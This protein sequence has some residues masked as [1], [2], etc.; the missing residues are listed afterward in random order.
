LIIIFLLL[1][2]LLRVWDATR[3]PPGFSTAELAV[4]Y[5]VDQDR[6][7]A[8][9]FGIGSAFV[10]ELVGDG[11]LGFRVFPIWTSLITLALLFV[12][13]RR[14]FGVPVA[15]IALGIMALNLRAIILAR[16]VTAESLIPIYVLL[17]LICL[18]GTFNVRDEVRF[19][20][21]T[22]LSFALLAVLLGGSGYLHYSGLILGPIGILFFIHL[23]ITR[24]PLSRRVWSAWVFLLALA[25]IVAIPYLVSTLREPEISEPYILVAARPHSLTDAVNGVLSAVGGVIWQGD[26]RADNNLPEMPLF[27]PVTA[28][29]LIGGVISAVRRW[30]EPRYA[31]LLI[32]LVAGL[33]T[34]AWVEPESTFSANL[35]ALPALMMLPGLGAVELVRILRGR[36]VAQAWQPV[37]MIVTVGLIAS[38]FATRDHLFYDWKHH[39]Q[40][41]AAYHADLGYLAAYLDRT[42]DDLPVSFCTARLTEPLSAGLSPLQILPLMMHREDVPMRHSD[43]RGGIVLINAG[44]P[45]R[46]AFGSLLD[47]ANMPPELSEWLT[48]GEP[49]PVEG[50]VDGSVLRLDVEQ[51][52]RDAGGYW[53]T[54]SPTFFMPD[55]TGSTEQIAL[56]IALENN[57]TF[58]GYDP[59]AL[60]TARVAGGDPIVLVSYWRVDGPLPDDLGIFAHLLAYPDTES[61]VPL[62]EPWAEANALDVRPAELENR[63]FFA[64]VSYIWLSDSLAPGL[65]ALTVGAYT[66][67]VAVLENHLEVLDSAL[68]NQPHGER[69]LLGDVTVN[70]PPDPAEETTSN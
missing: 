63:D 35:V 68:N 65:Y 9:M 69:L 48:G 27:G 57:L 24:Q 18:I 41:R 12:L 19:R 53:A 51:Q 22:T 62:L 33:L 26:A 61:R 28:L 59:R 11:L 31:L 23:L 29:L 13:A 50:L 42:P 30:R 40:T 4:Y 37:V 1:A 46:F 2:A 20:N 21:P 5:R 8:G 34:D 14:L 70:P 32:V 45:M 25:T 47:R 10:T 38:L 16:S 60:N 64:Q 44:A 43:C 52:V 6:M 54:F 55:A 56:P 36:G 15:L 49:I 7:H 58:A 66:R 67:E 3:L 17:T 39:V